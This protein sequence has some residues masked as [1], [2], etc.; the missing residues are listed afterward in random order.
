MHGE[1]LSTDAGGA[2]EMRMFSGPW[3]GPAAPG[4]SFREERF[5]P[6]KAGAA[7]TIPEKTAEDM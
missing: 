5:S 3:G 2:G 6:R 1:H 4:R 7:E